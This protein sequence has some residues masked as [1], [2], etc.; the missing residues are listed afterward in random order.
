[1]TVTLRTLTS[2]PGS[3][4]LSKAR[5]N[6]GH[7]HIDGGF[8]SFRTDKCRRNLPG[9]P[10]SFATVGLRRGNLDGGVIETGAVGE[11]GLVVGG[12]WRAMV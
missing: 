5:L 8:G 1:M 9:P 3:T 11:V 6:S 10:C 12:D 7:N 2:C 4:N